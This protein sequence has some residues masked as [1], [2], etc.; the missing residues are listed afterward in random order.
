MRTKLILPLFVVALA[1]IHVAD[2]RAAK[3]D[4]S[5]ANR[6]PSEE[7]PFINVA[8]KQVQ[9]IKWALHK[10]FARGLKTENDE[11]KLVSHVRAVDVSELDQ[12]QRTEVPSG[13]PFAPPDQKPDPEKPKA[14]SPFA[15]WLKKFEDQE[16]K[17]T[18]GY[19]SVVDENVFTDL[20]MVDGDDASKLDMGG[21]E[22]G[23]VKIDDYDPLELAKFLVAS[24]IVDANIHIRATITGTHSTSDQGEWFALHSDDPYW[25]NKSNHASYSFGIHIAKDGTI[26]MINRRFIGNLQAPEKE[27]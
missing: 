20:K 25:T 26:R 10:N 5:L 27:E 8:V 9:E 2:L 3:P 16:L 19:T 21:I 17:Y 1:W 12:S 11:G 18:N 13:G 14:K 24:G 7:R 6:P 23:R 15:V 4:P 22:I